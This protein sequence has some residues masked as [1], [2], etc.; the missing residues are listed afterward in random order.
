MRKAKR[1]LD[2]ISSDIARPA[3]PTEEA[4]YEASLI[5]FCRCFK[6]AG[7]IR[8][9]PLKPK[10][11]FSQIQRGQFELLKIIRDRMVAHDEQLASATVALLIR[12]KEH[13][14]LDVLSSNFSVPFSAIMERKYLI[15]LV[16][17]VLDW[18]DIER[19]KLAS[20]LK[21]W[22]DQMPEDRVSAPAFKL[23]II[24]GDPFRR[25]T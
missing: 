13:Y 11:V 12:S 8:Q 16:E 10:Q 25:G 22:F 21:S 4:L 17:T 3:T 23:D 20:D 19:H 6:G 2:L 1:W 5:I 7:G 15:G 18:L 9:R 24:E 14:A